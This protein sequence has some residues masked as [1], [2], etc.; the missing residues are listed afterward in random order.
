MTLA[1]ATSLRYR[2][3]VR[4][5]QWLVVELQRRGHQARLAA[6]DDPSEDWSNTE[7]VVFRSV[8]GYQ[9]DVPRFSGWL[10]ELE[11]NGTRTFNPLHMIRDNIFKDC[12]L[13]WLRRNGIPTIDTLVVSH[14]EAVQ[15]RVEPGPSLESTL[16]GH[17]PEWLD[18]PVVIKPIIS[19]SG[20]DTMRVDNAAEGEEL[21]QRIVDDHARRGA[22]VQPFIPG[23]ADGE[24]SF[25]FIGDAFSH[26]VR[27][28]PGVTFERRK[29]VAVTP[30]PEAMALAEQVFRIIGEPTAY[31]R[32]DI[33]RAPDGL[34]VMEVELVEPALFLGSLDSTYRRRAALHRLRDAVH[35]E[36]EPRAA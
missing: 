29:A 17:R 34:R 7:H 35:A 27:R 12:Q 36:V 3:I 33:V 1:V 28:F 23:V 2:R 10:D 30:A 24:L 19:A 5:D 6:W 22:L 14:D 13:A 20:R 11:R 16:E 18:I 9:D 32:I 4:E 8:W 15:E 25:I 31:A 21:F 26:C